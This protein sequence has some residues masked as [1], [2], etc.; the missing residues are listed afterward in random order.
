[1]GEEISLM[2]VKNKKELGFT[3]LELLLVLSVASILTAVIIPIGSKWIQKT[4]E[5]E[6]I[7][8]LISTIYSMQSYSMAHGVVT[9][10]SFVKNGN[11]TKYTADRPGR[12]VFSETY[13]PEGMKVSPNANLKSIEFNANGDIRSFG[14]LTL[15]TNAGIVELK[16]QFLRGRVIISESK[17]LFMAGNDS[18]T[19]GTR[20]NFWNTAPACNENDLD[21]I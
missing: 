3:F 1:M 13:L 4:S 7:Q 19:H 14:T 16:F 17:R 11:V 2:I 9:R 6:A 12:E 10:V 15:I 8:L 18:Y 20:C 21:A 5:E